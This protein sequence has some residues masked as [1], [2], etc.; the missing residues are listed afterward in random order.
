MWDN[1]EYDIKMLKME[2]DYMFLENM[3]L[4]NSLEMVIRVA[5]KNSNTYSYMVDMDTLETVY[6]CEELK[7][8]FPT[9]S[10]GELCYKQFR[11]RTTPCD[12]CLLLMLDNQDECFRKN[13]IYQELG[14]QGNVSAGKL[15]LEGHE[16]GYFN[17]SNIAKAGIAVDMRVFTSDVMLHNALSKSTDDYIYMCDIKQNLWHFTK[18]M[19]EDFGMPKEVLI[20]A[21]NLWKSV[22]HPDDRPAFEEDLEKVFSGKTDIHNVDYRAKRQNGEWTWLRCRGKMQYNE[23]GEQVMFA[24][25]VTDLGQRNKVDYVSGLLNKY[26]LEKVVHD[27]ITNE[28]TN[29]IGI[30]L[31]GI[32][33]FKHVNNLYGW[34]FGDSVIRSIAGKIE[35]I[36]PKDI[37]LFRLNGDVFGLLFKNTDKEKV[38]NMYEMVKCSFNE[39]QKLQGNR[40]FCTFS[41]GCI[42]TLDRTESVYNLLKK[43]EY[44]LDCAKI[45]G[46]N[47]L[48]FYNHEGSSGRERSLKLI[49]DL[50]ESVDNNFDSFEVYYQPQVEAKTQK[51][52][53]AEALLR[54][55]CEDFGVVGPMEFIPLLEE[56]G[57]ICKVENWVCQNAIKTCK[58]WR[59]INPDFVVSVNFSYLHI[60]DKNFTTNLVSM[61]EKEKLEVAAF[62]LEITESCIAFGSKALNTAFEEI[63]SHGF[64][65]EMD[66]FGTGYSSLEV[67][68]NKPSDVVKIDK[69]FV[70]NI[71]SCDF[72][73]TFISFVVALCHC[74][75]IKVCLE[76][77][78]TNEEYEI[79]K[80]MELDIIQGYLF[81]RPVSKNDFKN[82]YLK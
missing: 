58:E 52:I 30:L 25:I 64:I 38:S 69:T 74:V 65:I 60:L 78:E 27:E 5:S 7:K 59:N 1:R 62:H 24:G 29:N 80:D 35:K 21:G 67:L 33:N 54:W 18:N 71:T 61:L 76:G 48:E 57:L 37:G 4:C 6:I 42:I 31:L 15:I 46:K 12:N 20:D 66:D 2:E 49:Q 28:T 50:R 77:V 53:G 14:L 55:K 82:Q 51:V 43:A 68:K 40:Y 11:G 63:K 47:K 45:G 79:V 3:N 41:G 26:E 34:E 56:A 75:D 10:L 72:D 13:V 36:L 8:M 39:Q 73:A 32:D 81:G 70:A 19:V 17:I 16:I 23:K 9:A 22:I 44:A